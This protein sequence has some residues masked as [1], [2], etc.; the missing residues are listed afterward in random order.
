MRG[1][2]KAA[3]ER[4]ELLAP[5][6]LKPAIRRVIDDYTAFVARGPAP[7]QHDDAKGFAAHHGAGKVALAHLEHLLKLAR[8]AGAAEG[9]GLREAAELLAKARGALAET[10]AEEQGEEEERD[11]EDGDGG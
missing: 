2:R 5:E 6:D 9:E 4:Q 10:M 3:P 11:A 1:R 7:G 8:E